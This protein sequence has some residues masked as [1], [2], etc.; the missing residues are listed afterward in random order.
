MEIEYGTHVFI[1]HNISQET[2][3]L[4]SFIDHITL[5]DSEYKLTGIVNFYGGTLVSSGHYTAFI[6]CNENWTQFDD[7]SRKPSNVKS[8]ATINPHLIVYIKI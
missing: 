1:E 5:N 2:Y 7:L 4:N 6:K 3:N 8:N